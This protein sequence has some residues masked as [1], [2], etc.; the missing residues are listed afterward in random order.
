MA[1]TDDARTI[2][3]MRWVSNRVNIHRGWG[4]STEVPHCTSS[5]API[6]VGQFI[7][8]KVLPITLIALPVT[9]HGYIRFAHVLPLLFVRAEKLSR[10]PN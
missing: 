7:F 6:G 10:L 8:F 2:R 1:R 3:A 5:L 9:D 4:H